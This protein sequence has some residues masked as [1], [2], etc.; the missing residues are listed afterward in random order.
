MR[1]VAFTGIA[2][3]V[4]SGATFFGGDVK[5]ALI[6]SYDAGANPTTGMNPGA[7]LWSK[8]GGGAGITE[9][10]YNGTTTGALNYFRI[11][12]STGATSENW[13]KNL[14]AGDVIDASGWTATARFRLDST[15]NDV[16]SIFEVGDGA[17]RYLLVF[18]KVGGASPITNVSYYNSSSTL[19]AIGTFT[20][21]SP[22]ADTFQMRYDSTDPTQVK[23]YANGVPLGNIPTASALSGSAA[24]RWLRF[25]TGNS[26][27]TSDTY[28]NQVKFETGNTIV[29]VPEPAGA[30]VSTLAASAALL[31]RK[32]LA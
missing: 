23:V 27:A 10:I 32:R 6:A 14:T 4:M 28:W 24:T 17:K 16:G 29:L 30:A 8:A 5:A 31:R 22:N 25:G 9:T 18:K 1:K 21:A 2:V 20:Y 13:N 15:S 11:L 19:T 7:Q 3:L 26:S 12:D